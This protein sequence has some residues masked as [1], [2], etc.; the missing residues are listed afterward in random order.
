MK[1]ERP[2]AADD[3]VAWDHQRDR[4]RA[5]CAADSA[6][7]RVQPSRQFAANLVAGLAAWL[8]VFIILW[9]A[10]ARGMKHAGTRLGE[11]P[12]YARL[13]TLA[14]ALISLSASLE[15]RYR[16]RHSAATGANPERGEGSA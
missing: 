13:A 3:A 5:A 11:Y 15:G 12:W 10:H 16:C 4:V 6:R 8:I 7:R 9:V 1:P 2:L 14:C